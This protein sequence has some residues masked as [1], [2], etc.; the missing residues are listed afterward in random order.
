MDLELLTRARLLAQQAT[1]AA[2]EVIEQK[3]EPISQEKHVASKLMADVL[4][5][6]LENK[7]DIKQHKSS[8]SD[9]VP[10]DSSIESNHIQS[11]YKSSKPEVEVQSKKEGQNVKALDRRSE[12]VDRKSGPAQVLCYI[13]CAEFGTKSLSIHQKTCLKKQ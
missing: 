3:L 10:I 2:D 5:S 12:M 7:F 8:S 13:C 9:I 6:V 11:D 1:K 4:G